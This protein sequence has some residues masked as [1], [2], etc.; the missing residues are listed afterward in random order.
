MKLLALLLAMVHLPG[1][2]PQQPATD[3]NLQTYQNLLLGLKFDYPK[4]W[5]LTTNKSSESRI[6]IPIPES[7]DRAV[8]EVLPVN[9]RDETQIWQLTQ[10]GINKTMKRDVERQWDEEILGVPLLLTKVAYV[11]EGSPKT[12][13]TG[14]LYT[15][16]FNKMMYRITAAPGEF[17]D[18]DHQ[19]RKVLQSLR[20][21]DGEMPIAEDPT[22][23]IERK[24]VPR[25]GFAPDEIPHPTIPHEIN[26][27]PVIKPVK[28][29]IAATLDF[30]GKKLTLRIPTDWKVASNK[31]GGFLLSCPGIEGELNLAIYPVDGADPPE[32]ALQK[33]SADALNEF[34]TV[35]S[36][37]ESLPATNRAGASVASIWR[38]GAGAKGSLFSFEGSCRSGDY[39]ALLTYLSGNAARWNGAEAAI[40]SLMDR[41]SIEPAP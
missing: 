1:Q 4:T 39:Y 32:L 40:R 11:E 2:T 5:Q 28:S 37:D 29:P 24:E 35:A 30:S 10:I 9:F 8:I 7:S 38:G 12:S 14:L 27:Q 18:V 15:F 33:A 31:S 19:W 22:K 21:W 17:D 26:S 23:K 25:G 36:R 3:P 20:T 41:I 16:G 34:S 13:E 6:L